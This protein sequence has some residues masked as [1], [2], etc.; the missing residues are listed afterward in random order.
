MKVKGQID[1]L[2]EHASSGSR[3]YSWRADGVYKDRLKLTSIH[4]GKPKLPRLTLLSTVATFT[5]EVQK[6]SKARRHK[7][8]AVKTHSMA[9]KDGDGTKID[10]ETLNP[11]SSISA[12]VC[13][14]TFS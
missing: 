12:W 10:I 8:T 5:L 9:L 7:M 2:G 13:R 3:G 4:L 11:A 14:L 1:R 6:F